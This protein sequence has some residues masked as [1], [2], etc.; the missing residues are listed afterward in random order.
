MS[1]AELADA[2]SM[3]RHRLRAFEHRLVEP[4]DVEV[5][6]LARALR[7]SPSMLRGDEVEFVHTLAVN[8]DHRS[9]RVRVRALALA[10]VLGQIVIP[11]ILKR[12]EWKDDPLDPN[13][14]RLRRSAGSWIEPFDEGDLH[15]HPPDLAADLVRLEMRG[16]G[17]GPLASVCDWIQNLG[18]WCFSLPSDLREIGPCS[19]WRGRL[20]VIVVPESDPPRTRFDA[21]AQLGRLVLHVRGGGSRR[22]NALEAAR[23]AEALLL[24]TEALGALNGRVD[25]ASVER[26][27]RHYSLAPATVLRRIAAWSPLRAASARA[28]RS[29]FRGAGCVFPPTR[30][31]PQIYR[32]MARFGRPMREMVAEIGFSWAEWR[33][34]TFD[35]PWRP[36]RAIAG[37]G[38]GTGVESGRLRL[39]K[40]RGGRKRAPRNEATA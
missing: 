23:F 7:V 37:G 36:W 28:L 39:V 11:A 8:V 18:V 30:D 9:T 6:M 27:T 2:A 25:R 19:F 16:F 31:R 17:C 38:E 3:H 40:R 14:V 26:L 35:G 34:L 4:R 12:F 24:P 5:R 1:R 21:A 33:E 29:E 20:R 10:T 13:V 15:M 22:R 32:E